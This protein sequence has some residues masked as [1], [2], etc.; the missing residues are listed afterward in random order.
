MA[1]R[2]FGAKPLTET[3]MIKISIQENEF[4]KEVCKM[5][6]ILFSSLNELNIIIMSLR[7]QWV[8]LEVT[9]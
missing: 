2:R 1:C 3:M 4:E 5:A 8:N 7:G 9:H 6:A